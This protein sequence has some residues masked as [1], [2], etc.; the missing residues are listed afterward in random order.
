VTWLN[1][2]LIVAIAAAA[3]LYMTHGDDV[4]QFARD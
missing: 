2:Y 1:N 4:E 3:L